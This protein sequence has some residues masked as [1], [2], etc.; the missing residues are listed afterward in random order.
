MNR[1]GEHGV[2]TDCYHKA[3]VFLGCQEHIIILKP[4][5]NPV[6]SDCVYYLLRVWYIVNEMTG[7][8]SKIIG[9]Q[10]G[11]LFSAIFIM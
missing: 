1:L 8:I 2:G 3:Q 4:L 11:N 10:T 7:Q 9:A 6:F 5:K